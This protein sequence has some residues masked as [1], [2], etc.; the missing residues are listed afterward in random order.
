MSFSRKNSNVARSIIMDYFENPKN[1]I[2][3]NNDVSNYLKFHSKSESCVD[4]ITICLE[5]NNN[6]ILDA[7][8]YGMGCAISMASSEILTQLII[9]K[10]IEES[11]LII[12]TFNDLLKGIEKDNSESIL[13][14][15]IVFHNVYSQSNRVKCATVASNG[16]S[17]I[18]KI[19]KN[20]ITQ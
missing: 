16:I 13:E 3:E 8:Y 12:S 11:E 17:E 18:F 2:K 19:L 4:D 5:I 20:K 14:D 15:L 7:K 10:T 6:K 9:N 1:K